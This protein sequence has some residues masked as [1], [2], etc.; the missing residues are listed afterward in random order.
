[1]RTGPMQSLP[2]QL[3]AIRRRF[4]RWRLTR[5][6]RSRIPEGLWALAVKA[7]GLYGLYRT[8]QALGLDYDSLKRRVEAA[9][10]ERSG[11]TT[12]LGR[13]PERIA[14]A[15]VRA[16]GGETVAKFVELAP[17]VAGGPAECI[18]EWEG[19]RG[20]RMRIYLKGLQAADLTALSRSFWSL[21]V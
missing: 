1:M 10:R 16:A 13:R 5:Q 2:V 9:R 6:G 18:L 14:S 7:A 11:P 3:A 20:T 12:A 21:E 4:D 15:K 19:P 17:P 8:V